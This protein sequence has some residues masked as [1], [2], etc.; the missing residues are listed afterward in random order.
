MKTFDEIYEELQSGDNNELNNLWKDAKN[1]SEKAN[2]TALTI[3]LIIDILAIILFFSIGIKVSSIF[4][5]IPLLIPV[6][7]INLFVYIIVNIIFSGKETIKYHQ[8][9]KSVVINKLMNNFYDNLEYFPN[10]EMPEYIYE[11]LQYEHYDIYESEDYMEGQINNKY[12]IQ[13]AEIETKEEEEYKDSDGETQTREITKFHGL[14]A[15]I[16][17]D[18]SINSELKIGQNGSFAFAKSL[19]M[20]SSEFEKYFDVQASNQ[21]IG[22]QLL[23]ADVMEELIDF[24][25]KTNMEFDIY[26]KENELYLRFHSGDMFEPANL[27]K[28]AL[29]KDLIQKYF[30]ML[31]FTYNLSNRLI[32]LVNETEL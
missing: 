17:M 26:I 29:D 22:M 13:M 10:K 8:K 30:Y 11:K 9:Y 7:V 16:G 23:T 3:C 19:K 20:D 15:K 1:K 25:N 24:V 12:S 4:A 5:I 21:I 28:G 2:K 6:L 18:K 31:N 32:K 14:F 27:K